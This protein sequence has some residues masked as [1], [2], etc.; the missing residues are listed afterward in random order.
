MGLINGV[1][2]GDP[3]VV[4]S[5]F[6]NYTP[7]SGNRTAAAVAAASPCGTITACVTIDAV[8]ARPSIFAGGLARRCYHI[9]AEADSLEG[10]K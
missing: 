8:G 1:R 5:P 7:T 9:R 2:D 10:G 6:T 3:R 4:T